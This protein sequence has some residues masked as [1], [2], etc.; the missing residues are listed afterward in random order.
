MP[1]YAARWQTIEPRCAGTLRHTML[2][3]TFAHA[4]ELYSSGFSSRS[5]INR[6]RGNG[7]G[8]NGVGGLQFQV[9]IKITVLEITCVVAY[10]G[11]GARGDHNVLLDCMAQRLPLELPNSI[12]ATGGAA[13]PDQ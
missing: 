1:R 2:C 4:T 3:A 7:V 11:Q 5:A 10:L 13:R 9:L 12:F 8:A 6:R